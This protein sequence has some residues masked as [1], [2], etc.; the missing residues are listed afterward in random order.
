MPDRPQLRCLLDPCG[1]TE[2]R[3]NWSDRAHNCNS[4]DHPRTAH[5][6]LTEAQVAVT[7]QQ[8]AACQRGCC[9]C[10]AYQAPPV[11][12]AEPPPMDGQ[13]LAATTACV[14]DFSQDCAATGREAQGTVAPGKQAGARQPKRQNTLF[15]FKW[16]KGQ[17]STRQG[18]TNSSA[19]KTAL[20]ASSPRMR[21]PLPRACAGC[22]HGWA[23]HRPPTQDDARR[24]RELQAAAGHSCVAEGCFVHEFAAFH[25]GEDGPTP[26]T[27]VGEPIVCALCPHRASCHR[28][29]TEADRT[30]GR[31]L[32]QAYAHPCRSEL[33]ATSGG[34]ST[35]DEQQSAFRPVPEI[36][37]EDG[38]ERGPELAH[39]CS[40]KGFAPDSA[41]RLVEGLQGVL[42]ADL[43]TTVLG[44]RCPSC[45]HDLRHHREQTAAEAAQQELHDAAHA[46]LLGVLSYQ[47]APAEDLLVA[48][49]ARRL[50]LVRI[51]G[52][53]AE[54]HRSPPYM[55]SGGPTPAAPP[56]SSVT[57]PPKRT[58]R[59]QTGGAGGAGEA[60]GWTRHD[61]L[62]RPLR[63]GLADLQRALQR[64]PAGPAAAASPSS[65]L[66]RPTSYS[67]HSSGRLAV[68]FE[69]GRVSVVPMMTAPSLALSPSPLDTPLA[70]NTDTSAV[71]CIAW[72]NMPGGE[73]LAYA[74]RERGLYVASVASISGEPGC[75]SSF[76]V[77][78]TAGSPAVVPGLGGA[79]RLPLAPPP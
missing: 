78:L 62:V 38:S 42:P 48:A 20:R 3:R 6:Q 49:G 76:A 52:R 41:D 53:T 10:L 34:R 69:S 5:A 31:L 29:P 23:E 28:A 44:A 43:E 58:K 7:R 33:A 37:S 21:R 72:E 26:V 8:T 67:A 50:H 59:Q 63:S 79:C 2:F 30:V 65:P 71:V 55:P 32:L 47:S 9:G 64:R 75:H 68:G 56:K 60:G 19:P 14:G 36:R 57:P 15:S 13:V 73:R 1:C 27:Q 66:W 4:C 54:F 22:G 25:P 46:S 39:R 18:T 45:S 17:A 51:G 74:T 61:D 12:P 77:I 24:Q 40:C 11:A 70:P 16:S 35:V